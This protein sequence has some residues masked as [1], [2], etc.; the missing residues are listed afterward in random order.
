MLAI[1][2]YCTVSYNGYTYNIEATEMHAWIACALETIRPRKSHSD[3][4]LIWVLRENSM[5]SEETETEAHLHLLPK[6]TLT[7]TGLTA[8]T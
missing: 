4:R 7:S 3:S 8:Q 6:Q 5:R 2:Q 1:N